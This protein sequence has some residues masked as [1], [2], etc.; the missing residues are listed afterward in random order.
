MMVYFWLNSI[1]LRMTTMGAKRKVSWPKCEDVRG[2]SRRPE[3]RDGAV[4]IGM[5]K[6]TE[7]A[8]RFS[9]PSAI[10]M[11]ECSCEVA[12][13]YPECG[14]LTPIVLAVSKTCGG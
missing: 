13:T 11:Q 10:P 3:Y 5:R 2:W 7:F 6:Y 9:A 14:D 8:T 1:W 12:S 4:R